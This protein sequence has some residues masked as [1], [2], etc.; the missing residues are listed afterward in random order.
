MTTT[1]T[2]VVTRTVYRTGCGAYCA[3][4]ADEDE[5]NTS[6]NLPDAGGAPTGG[7]WLLLRGSE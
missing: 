7:G 4:V 6:G 2:T 1:G 3:C 5:A